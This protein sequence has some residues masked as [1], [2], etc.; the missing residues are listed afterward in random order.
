VPLQSLP[1]REGWKVW[2][3]SAGRGMTPIGGE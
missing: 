3:E 2:G 1:G